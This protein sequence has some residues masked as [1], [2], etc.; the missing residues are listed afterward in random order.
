MPRLRWFLFGALATLLALTVALAAVVYSGRYPIG[1][2]RPHLPAT[3]ALIDALR[4]H[5]T[6]AA[7]K[8]VTVPRLGDP[9]QVAKGAAHYDEMCTGC[10]RAPGQPES[11]LRL[12]LYPQPPD[13]TRQGIDDPAEAF[14]IIKHGIKLTAMP[15][16]G[17]SHTDAQIWALVAFLQ[18]LPRLTPTQYRQRVASA[19]A[20]DSGHGH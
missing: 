7:A 18:Q 10:H 4:D 9:M 16:W 14:W 15:A 20:M 5:A 17:K 1:A 19:Q 3:R 8:S 6:E 11:E 2:D 13:L 12:G